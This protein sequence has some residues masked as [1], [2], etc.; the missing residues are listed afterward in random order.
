MV[1]KRISGEILYNSLSDIRGKLLKAIGVLGLPTTQGLCHQINYSIVLRLQKDLGLPAF[2]YDRRTRREVRPDSPVIGYVANG[3]IK[4]GNEWTNHSFPLIFGIEDA[5]IIV[6]GSNDQYDPANPFLIQKLGRSDYNSIAS[7]IKKIG[8]GF[9][10]L[11]VVD[12]YIL[13]TLPDDLPPLL[14]AMKK[15][16]EFTDSD[17]NLIMSQVDREKQLGLVNLF[18]GLNRDLLSY[19]ARSLGI[20]YPSIQELRMKLIWKLK[21]KGIN[22]PLPYENIQFDSLVERLKQEKVI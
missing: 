5:P 21:D 12:R 16:G 20:D 19:F 8:H 13:D 22:I 6:D 18:F 1:E 4:I 2:H 11:S 7:A 10:E 15:I 3:R 17:V 9:A 14:K